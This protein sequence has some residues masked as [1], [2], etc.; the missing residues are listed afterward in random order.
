MGAGNLSLFEVSMFVTQIRED[1]E[2]KETPGGK[3]SRAIVAS[4]S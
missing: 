4:Y 2:G 3:N 1:R